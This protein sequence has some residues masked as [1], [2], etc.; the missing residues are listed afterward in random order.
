LL[1]FDPQCELGSTS[2]ATH[3]LKARY[4][5]HLLISSHSCRISPELDFDQAEEM[6]LSAKDL[7]ELTAEDEEE[8]EEA[9]AWTQPYGYA[10]QA[11]PHPIPSG[12]Y[13]HGGLFRGLR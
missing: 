4:H 9:T 8:D 12:V 13:W 1:L 7:A 5:Q 2:L 11:A 3:S 10:G 6:G